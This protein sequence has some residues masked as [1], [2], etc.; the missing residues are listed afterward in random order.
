MGRMWIVLGVLI[1]GPAAAAELLVFAAASTTDA[2]RDVA[3]AY[4]QQ[5][6]EDRVVFSFA[7]SHELARQIAAGAKADVFLSAD[8][9]KMAPLR[10]AKVV[11]LLSNSLVVVARPG[12]VRSMAELVK[13]K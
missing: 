13:V 3:A 6:P 11:E 12:S 8:L 5:H 4:A 10:P 2:M 1:A 9:A 7:G